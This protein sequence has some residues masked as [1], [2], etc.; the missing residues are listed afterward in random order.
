[1]PVRQ[2]HGPCTTHYQPSPRHGLCVALM[3]KSSRLDRSA[4][5]L[6]RVVL[7]VGS[8]H[9]DDR[10]AANQ[11]DREDEPRWAPFRTRRPTTPWSGPLTTSTLSPSF[12]TWSRV[13]W[14][15]GLDELT[16]PVDLAFGDRGR[17]AV[18]G[19]DVDNAGW[20]VP[21]LDG[22]FRFP[23]ATAGV[24]VNRPD[25]KASGWTR[26][27]ADPSPTTTARRTCSAVS[28]GC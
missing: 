12:T 10:R 8:V 28:I 19:D 14:Q 3:F 18:D 13:V 21:S 1:M 15:I 6:T 4:V 11:S 2:E 17:R 16:N 20:R 27:S 23:R 25:A 24:T 5:G 26:T 22:T 9:L 7:D